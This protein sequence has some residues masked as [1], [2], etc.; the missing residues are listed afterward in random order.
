MRA[1]AVGSALA[2]S[3]AAAGMFDALPAGAAAGSLVATGPD[4]H[5]LRRATFGPTEELVKEI[6]RLGRNRWLDRQLDP[7]SVNDGFCQDYV[8]DR[9]PDLDMTVKRAYETFEGSWDLMYALGQATIVRAAWSKRQLFE[10][11][12]DFWSNHL[13]VTNPHEACWW[14]RHD[15]DRTVIRKHAL[16]KFSDMLRASATHPA[17][18]TYLNN[19]ESTKDNPNENYGREILELHS[20]GVDG[21]YDEEDMRQSTLALT[22]FGISWDTGAFEYHD[23]AHYTGPVHVMG[24]HA[25]N[26]NEDKG[27]DVGLA[28]VDYLAH[29]PSTAERI[30]R[31]LCYRFVSDDPPRV[32]RGRARRDLPRPRH[33][34]RAGAREA[35]PLEGVR[36]LGRREGA[37]PVRGRGRHAAHPGIRP[38][39]EGV[40]GQQ[41]LYWMIEGLGHLPMGWVPPDGYPDTGDPV[42][43]GRPHAR[44]MEHARR[45][46]GGLVAGEPPQ[47]ARPAEEPA[48]GHASEDARRARRRRWPSASCSASSR[49]RTATRSLAFLGVARRHPARR[50]RRGRGLA[51]ALPGG[52]DPR[53]AQPRDPVID[54]PEDRT[55][56]LDVTPLAQ[57]CGCPAQPE[58]SRRSFLKAAGRDRHRG[59]PRERGHVHAARVRRDALRGRRARRALA[60]RRHGQPAG[61]RP[62]RGGPVR[63]LRE[64]APEHRRAPGQLLPLDANFGMHPAMAPLKPFYD[65]GSLGIV[66]AVG[67]AQPNRSHFSAMEEMER[68]APGTRCARD[69]SIGCWGCATRARP[70]QATQLGSNSAASAFLGPAPE[71]AMWNI[72]GFDLSGAWDA[73]EEAPWDAAL[74]GVHDGAPP[75]IAA[76]ALTA[77]D[78]LVDRVAAARCRL[79]ARPTAPPIRT[80]ASATPCAT[81]RA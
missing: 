18:M 59:R 23:W 78:A 50:R 2:G 29:H 40:D 14:S 41:G 48:A 69:G 3:G 37:P 47:G 44:T 54:M 28:Y 6:R 19:A 73:S 7:S 74:R 56:T 34:D 39:P 25:A 17:M 72:D 16:G 70:F 8:A 20:V 67:M 1:A 71:L 64:L 33:G 43:V 68:A 35:V 10:V 42:A 51:P 36:P 11:M 38:D 55:T 80:P 75:V 45:A 65:A 32:A 76:P 31:K 26:G 9:Y 15:Y 61:G 66:N 5:L 58:I 27:K 79:H 53:H 12:V 46:R 57:P 77:L 52:V 21:G 30:A 62:R 81:W 49:P 4:L 63:P 13:N 24:W 60:A 22:G